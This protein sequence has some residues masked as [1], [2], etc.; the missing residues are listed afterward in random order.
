[1][2]LAWL[3]PLATLTCPL[4][5]HAQPV[6][7]VRRIGWLGGYAMDVPFGQGVRH[8]GYVEGRRPLT[9]TLLQFRKSDQLEQAVGLVKLR[10]DRALPTAPALGQQM[11]IVDGREGH[12]A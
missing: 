10:Q 8:F 6:A 4:A 9:E 1:M 2:R 3:A 12:A 11:I 5:A 7:S